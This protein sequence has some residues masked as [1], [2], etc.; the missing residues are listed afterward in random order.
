MPVQKDE[1]S[2]QVAYAPC[3]ALWLRRGRSNLE[4]RVI[5]F[6]ITAYAE[7]LEIARMTLYRIGDYSMKQ[8]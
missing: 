5:G 8:I 6:S 1:A 7:S 3:L 2:I 4:G